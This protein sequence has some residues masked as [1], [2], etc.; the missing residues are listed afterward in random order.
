MEAALEAYDPKYIT[1]PRRS[2]EA[3]SGLSI[4]P[5]KR[6]GR[7]QEEHLK[8]ASYI[9]SEVKG[10]KNWRYKPPVRKE[11]VL[12]WKKEHPSGKICDCVKDTGLSR[13]TVNKYWNR[14]LVSAN[15]ELISLYFRIGK[16][17]SE[18]SSYG[19]NFIN[20]LSTA[21]KLDF[22]DAEGYSPRNLSRMKKFY[23]TYK[24]LS[25]LPPAVAKLPWTHNCILID[26]VTNLSER[27][28]YAQQC[29]ENKRYVHSK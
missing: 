11:D 4:P 16:I 8:I 2:I 5:N 15:Q 23:E 26:K 29:I 1:Y 20:S 14:V 12:S 25:I 9:Q 21:L 22:P 24:D 7:T 17:I 13:S 28:W 3:F 27:E 10:Q 18:N 19:N 6:N